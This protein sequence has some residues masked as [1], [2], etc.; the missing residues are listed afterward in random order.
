M[1][2]PLL[3]TIPD[4]EHWSAHDKKR[5]LKILHEKGGPSARGVDRMIR[6]HDRLSAALRDL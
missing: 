2:A 5:L 3:A 4:L 1:L 6:A